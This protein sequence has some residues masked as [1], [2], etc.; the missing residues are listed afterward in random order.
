MSCYAR[1]HDEYANAFDCDAPDVGTSVGRATSIGPSLVQRLDIVT[2]PSETPAAVV[3]RW[4]PPSFVGARHLG[5]DLLRRLEGPAVVGV[6]P[7]LTR[8]SEGSLAVVERLERLRFS[9]VRHSCRDCAALPPALVQFRAQAPP[10]PVF[11]SPSL[12]AF[13]L[14]LRLHVSALFGFVRPFGSRALSP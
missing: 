12:A 5:G 3:L 4:R 2:A 10:L 11:A 8:S 14:A 1:Q 9:Q 7:G 6:T 13:I